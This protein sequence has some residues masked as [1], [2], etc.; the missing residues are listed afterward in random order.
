MWSLSIKW[1]VE[2]AAQLYKIDYDHV[3]GVTVKVTDEFLTDEQDGPVTYREGK[4]KACYKNKR[5]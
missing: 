2:A 5:A 4:W 1:A 3:I